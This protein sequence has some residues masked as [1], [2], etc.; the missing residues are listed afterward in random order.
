M[1]SVQIDVVVEQRRSD[2]GFV[3]GPIDRHLLNQ[4]ADSGVPVLPAKTRPTG[5]RINRWTAGLFQLSI[6]RAK[7]W[8][9][10]RPHI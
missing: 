4:G 8:C 5:V 3:P 6:E 10:I 9:P 7:P 1:S 2:G